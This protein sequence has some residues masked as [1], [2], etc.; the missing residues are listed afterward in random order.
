M[1]KEVFPKPS[2][3]A[4]IVQRKASA[5][6]TVVSKAIEMIIEMLCYRTCI[7]TR[8]RFSGKGRKISLS[9]QPCELGE[10]LSGH[11]VIFVAEWVF[12]SKSPCA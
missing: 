11:L 12:G 3:L 10:A 9:Q 1:G 6:I 4:D 8:F 2:T 5:A 7:R